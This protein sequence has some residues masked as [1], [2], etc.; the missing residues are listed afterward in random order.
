MSFAD[1][2]ME[3][4]SILFTVDLDTVSL[5]LLF[6]LLPFLRFGF[7]RWVETSSFSYFSPLTQDNAHIVG[8]CQGNELWLG[9]GKLANSSYFRRGQGLQCR[10]GNVQLCSFGKLLDSLAHLSDLFI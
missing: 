10:V 5:A 7:M 8:T 9:G 6:E 2:V 4:V 1:F 3:T